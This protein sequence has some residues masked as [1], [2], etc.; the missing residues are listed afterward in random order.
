VGSGRLALTPTEFEIL[1]L[2]LEH[3]RE[4]V[5]TEQS[6]L[7]VWGHVTYGSRNSVEA[8]IPRLRQKLNRVGWFDDSDNSRDRLCGSLAT[9]RTDQF[10]SG[11]FGK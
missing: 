6:A 5:E 4:V 3:R 8:Y 10:G 1:R 7:S 9:L 2:F 11:G